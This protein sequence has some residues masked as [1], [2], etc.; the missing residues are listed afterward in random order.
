MPLIKMLRDGRKDNAHASHY[1]RH[2]Q[3][4]LSGRGFR[5]VSGNRLLLL[6]CSLLSFLP[7]RPTACPSSQ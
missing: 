4:K 2:T 7:V 1:G 3:R 6:A 5:R